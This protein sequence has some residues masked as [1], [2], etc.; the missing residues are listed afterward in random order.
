MLQALRQRGI[1]VA[2]SMA[3]GYGREVATT[4]ALQRRTLEEAWRAW[5]AWARP[6]GLPG[7]ATVEQSAA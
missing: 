4:V 3:G 1:P 6:V 2:I 7:G 5:S